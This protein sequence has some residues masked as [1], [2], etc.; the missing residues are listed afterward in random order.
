MFA[1][2]SPRG[3]RLSVGKCDRSKGLFTLRKIFDDPVSEFSDWGTL[4]RSR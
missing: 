4:M 1:E 3:M 2:I